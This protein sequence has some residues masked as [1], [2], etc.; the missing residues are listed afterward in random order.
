MYSDDRGDDRN[1]AHYEESDFHCCCCL[2]DAMQ[3]I[4][5]I[6]DEIALEGLEGIT[7]PILWMR[8]DQRQPKIDLTLDDAAK[9]YIWQKLASL[10]CGIIDYFIVPHA[11]TYSTLDDNLN[12]C[13]TNQCL[14]DKESSWH[15]EN[16]PY[17]Y[18]LISDETNGIRGSCR[19]YYTRDKITSIIRNE[20]N[21]ANTSFQEATAMWDDKLVLVA[22]QQVRDRALFGTGNNP[23]FF[24]LTADQFCLL[25]R[26]GRARWRGETQRILAKYF[27]KLD[28]KNI[29]R[30]LKFLWRLKLITHQ[31]SHVK[32]KSS[33]VI[34]SNLLLLSRFHTLQQHNT[35]ESNKGLARTTY[36]KV[37]QA[38]IAD[39]FI[40]I[41]SNKRKSTPQSYIRLLKSY[42]CSVESD[43]NASTEDDSDNDIYS[44]FE[45]KM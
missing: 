2:E 41:I 40:D 6:I 30:K 1:F 27:L 39:G 24:N 4:A 11:R 34:R 12:Q 16:D 43:S 25:E 37:C 15:R 22:N 17:P 38:L 20:N 18:N 19:D 32:L 42:Q 10:P 26:I 14:M 23:S 8:I 33:S 44:L 36:R 29:F 28:F 9:E 21:T 13:S 3:A 7:L 31:T 5:A 45:K 35:R